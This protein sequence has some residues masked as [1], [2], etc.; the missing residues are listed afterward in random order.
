MIDAGTLGA[1]GAALGLAW[2]FTRDRFEAGAWTGKIAILSEAGTR[3]T[4]ARAKA[5]GVKRLD[6]MINDFPGPGA[7]FQ[8]LPWD[9]LR[10]ATLAMQAAGLRVSWT[11]WARPSEAWLEGVAQIGRLADELGV[12]EVSFDLEENWINALLGQPPATIAEWTRRLFASLR[13][14]YSGTVGVTH[15]VFPRLDVLGEA[16]KLADLRIPQAYATVKNAGNRSP[17]DL[18]RIAVERFK[19]YGPMTMGAAA[20]NTDGAYRLTGPAAMRAS[21]GQAIALGVTR[22]RFWRLE[23]IDSTEAQILAD[24]DRLLDRGQA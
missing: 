22:V 9:R 21:V 23:L 11:T 6:I 2:Y 4:I 16:L 17:G 15:I 13:S 7:P 10:A 24:F 14:T 3:A 12:D 20:W 19:G 8:V 5:A 1:L 18:E